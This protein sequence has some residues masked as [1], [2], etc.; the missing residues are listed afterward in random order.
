MFIPLPNVLEHAA[1]STLYQAQ[2]AVTESYQDVQDQ[3]RSIIK[4]QQRVS[5]FLKVKED[6]VIQL[7]PLDQVIMIEAE[8][9]YSSI[10]LT[11]GV[12]IFT[13]KTV[14]YWIQK[15]GEDHPDFVRTHRSFLINRN[16]ITGY[17]TADR[18]IILTSEKYAKVARRIKFTL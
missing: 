18:I 8:S 14:K 16:H 15:I 3:P 9:N 6:K 11:S 12:H 5:Q 17:K 13:S 10:Y 1:Y 7:I 4:L 2:D